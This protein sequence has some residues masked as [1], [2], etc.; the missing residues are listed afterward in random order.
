MRTKKLLLNFKQRFRILPRRMRL[1]RAKFAD[2]SKMGQGLKVSGVGLKNQQLMAL[3][4]SLL[5][6]YIHHW[7]SYWGKPWDEEC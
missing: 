4:Q 3:G 6:F 5:I 1:M 2:V 7:C